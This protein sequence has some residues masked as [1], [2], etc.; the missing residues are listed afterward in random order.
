MK[1]RNF[2]NRAGAFGLGFWASACDTAGRRSGSADS[3]K[4]IVVIG[5]G[6]AGLA[7]AQELQRLGHGVVVV[8]ARDRI[9]GRVWTSHQ[10]P[11]APLDFGATWI[12]GTEGN[13]I[14]ELADA[15]QAR[16]WVTNYDRAITYNTDGLPLSEAAAREL[17][18]L[19]ADLVQAIALAQDGEVDVSILKATESVWQGLDPSS[20][21]HR[22]INFV[23]N[24]DLEHEYAGS[25]AQLSAHWYDSG[26][27][28][29]GDDALFEQGFGVIAEALAEGLSIDLG[30]VVR[31]IQ[32]DQSPVRVITQQT[33]FLADQVVVTLPLGVLQA[34][35]VRF[36]PALPNDKQR[37]IARLGMGV[38]NKCYL[39]FEGAFWPTD[40]DWLE[41]ISANHGE[42]TEWVSFQRVARQ[43]ILLGFNAADQGQQIE[44]GSD[45]AIV[46][47]A[48][49]TL[50]T[51][52]GPDIS[53][54]IDAQITRWASD[55]FALGSYSYNALGATPRDRKM[56]AAPLGNRLFFAGEATHPDYF[57]TTHGA[58]LSGLRAAEEILAINP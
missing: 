46:A 29:D 18:R 44:A 17:G 24:G 26:Q 21:A 39:R 32:W 45:Q 56:L 3:P 41:Y 22:L 54:P 20:Q 30:Q 16:R 43:P 42:W 8:E 25:V 40:V 12:H 7:A 57:G 33:E 38:L 31:E 11:D 27:A 9:G 10:W 4:R 48:M 19:R 14:T 58:Y 6:L 35:R 13:P 37:V 55:P 51:I 5:A 52:F 28:F 50:K 47:S 36:T 1:R 49:D 15:L 2:L 34:G 53:D 23:L